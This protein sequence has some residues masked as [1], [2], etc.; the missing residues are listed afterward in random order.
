VSDI[1]RILE[2]SVERVEKWVEEKGYKGYEPF[3][4]L[5]SF[6]KPF[7]F[8]NLF[9]ERLLQQ[10]VRQSPSNLR[11]LLG[12]KPKE[13]TKGRGYMAWGY[14]NM[15]KLTGRNTYREKAFRCLDWLDKNKAP[16]YVYHSWGNHFHYS[17][18]SGRIPKYEPT[19]V[20]TSLIGQTFLEA[21]ELFG[22][23]EDLNIIKSISNWILQLP[24]EETSED[25]CLSYVP[26]KGSYVHNSNMLGAA[27]L[28]NAAQYTRDKRSLEVAG[29]A[30]KYSCSRQRP[31]GSWYYGED[32]IY[33]WIDNFHTGYN[34]DGLKRYSETTGDNTFDRNIENG[35]KYFRKYFFE[36]SGCPKYYH[37][38]RYP[39]DIQ[40]ASQG[41]DTLVNF[42]NYDG[43]N[44]ELACKV[45]KWTI[46]NMQN[47]DGHFYYRIYPF[48]IR[49]R[50][51]MIHWGQ[52]T[53]YKAL[54]ALLLKVNS[55]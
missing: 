53:T 43:G 38:R 46:D 3:D 45:A 1:K 31:D 8:H 30:M 54:S 51:P 13:S 5:S 47:G 42:S 40:C 10:L 29:R 6:L 20:W 52:A 27:F 14:L 44:L 35:F 55:N 17:S 12:V 21:Y 2:N 11:P 41:I 36:E 15:F 22:R 24:R 39:I 33:H 49:A 16:G 25:I 50:A 28:A 18:R 32:P 34:L 9:L 7:T 19:I 4:G 26:F 23:K 37:N 48:G